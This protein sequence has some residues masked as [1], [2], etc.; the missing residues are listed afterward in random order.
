MAIPGVWTRI[1]SADRLIPGRAVAVEGGYRVRGQWSLVSG[2][3][4]SDWIQLNC[5]VYDGGK[6]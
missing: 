6:P 4:I 2:C 3:Q 5:V 1:R